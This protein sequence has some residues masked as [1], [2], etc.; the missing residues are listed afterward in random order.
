MYCLQ[1]IQQ[2]SD[3]HEGSGERSSVNE[4]DEGTVCHRWKS[5]IWKQHR[6]A[7]F[8]HIY[9]LFY[10]SYLCKLALDKYVIISYVFYFQEE[11]MCKICHKIFN[12][13]TNREWHEKT[14][15]GDPNLSYKCQQCGKNW[16]VRMHWRK[17]KK[18]HKRHSVRLF[19]FFIKCKL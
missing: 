3:K 18:I 9:A 14:C 12:Y 4:E 10:I 1:G 11:L 19:L 17:H 2:T 6:A 13:I 5:I 8:V 16:K 15:S 7:H